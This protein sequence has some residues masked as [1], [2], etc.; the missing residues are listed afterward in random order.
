M[1]PKFQHLA[2]GQLCGFPP[3][4]IGVAGMCTGSDFD[5]VAPR[6]T[7]RL[8]TQTLS[9]LHARTSYHRLWEDIGRLTRLPLGLEAWRRVWSR[10][11]QLASWPNREEHQEP[12]KVAPGGCSQPGSS[13]RTLLLKQKRRSSEL[14]QLEAESNSTRT[15]LPLGRTHGSC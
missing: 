11:L 12:P 7:L 5:C 14:H 9:Q 3:H 15:S 10:S 6:Q 1:P 2:A 4:W 13:H 8:A